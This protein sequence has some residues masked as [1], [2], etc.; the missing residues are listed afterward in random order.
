MEC[1]GD[2]LS[3]VSSTTADADSEETILY[4]VLP[5]MPNLNRFQLVQGPDGKLVQ[6][7]E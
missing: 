6:Q 7:L 2:K 1:V 3:G 5:A 4:Y